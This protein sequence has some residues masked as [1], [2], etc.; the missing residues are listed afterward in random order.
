MLGREL[1][2]LEAQLRFPLLHHGVPSGIAHVG[3]R[4][5]EI[6]VHLTRDQYKDKNSVTEDKV[7]FAHALSDAANDAMR[8]NM[9]HQ[10]AFRI[11]VASG[12]STYDAGWGVVVAEDTTD[13][14]KRA[15]METHKRPQGRVFQIHRVQRGDVVDEGGGKRRRL[16]IPTVYAGIAWM[17]LLEARMACLMEHL[18]MRFDLGK[19][20]AVSFRLHA[21]GHYVSKDYHLDMW[22][23]DLGA[24][25]EI[26]PAEPTDKALCQAEAA[27]VAT[28]EVVYILWGDPRQCPHALGDPDPTTTAHAQ[29][30]R[31]L[32]F[33]W[34]DRLHRPR[35]E[36]GVCFMSEEGEHG[37]D[38]GFLAVR[39]APH[40]VRVYHRFVV[41]AYEAVAATDF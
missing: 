15:Y 33:V 22:L 7:T 13:A 20:V 39:D 14:E 23:P 1:S 8:W 34:S 38:R 18:G 16:C 35:M 17:S 6:F 36:R 11:K 31:G 41:R 4:V 37:R 26:K 24:H 9:D 25:V 30:V 27:C 28:K 5:H 40:D 10:V 19:T 2:E 32:R 12:L 21:T 29:G 3:K